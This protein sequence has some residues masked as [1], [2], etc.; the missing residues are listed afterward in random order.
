MHQ[1][2]PITPPSPPLPSALAATHPSRLTTA[3]WPI[4]RNTTALLI[5][6]EAGMLRQMAEGGRGAW[7]GILMKL[8]REYA[9]R[10]W[11]SDRAKG[12]NNI[13][14]VRLR[15]SNDR[16]RRARLNSAGF[17]LFYVIRLSRLN[18]LISVCSLVPYQLHSY[19]IWSCAGIGAFGETPS[20][21]WNSIMQF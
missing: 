19:H 20:H 7:P 5:Q 15:S 16:H 3:K 8:N 21:R 9:G 13:E 14:A 11:P 18:L 12:E 1:S 6:F 2:A 17:I 4:V 10:C